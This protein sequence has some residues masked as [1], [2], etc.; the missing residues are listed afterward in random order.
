MILEEE[1]GAVQQ[2]GRSDERCVFLLLRLVISERR[3]GP[4]ERLQKNILVLR[5]EHHKL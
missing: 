3:S 2:I 4:R 1:A 5:S